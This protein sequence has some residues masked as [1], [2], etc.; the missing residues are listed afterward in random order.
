MAFWKVKD[1]LLHQQMP[2]LFNLLIKIIQHFFFLG[3][4]RASTKPFLHAID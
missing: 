1:H 2:L 4:Y 3:V